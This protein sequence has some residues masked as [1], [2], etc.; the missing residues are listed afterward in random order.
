VYDYP[1]TGGRITLSQFITAAGDLSPIAV[2]EKVSLTRRIGDNLE[3][4]VTL[5]YAAI[6]QHTEP[7]IFLKPNDHISVGTS[8]GATPMAVIRNGFRTSYGFGFLL[9][10]NFGNDVFG[11]PPVTNRF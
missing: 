1:V 9:D 2:P 8:W 5:N 11:P 7:D 4:T 6:L 10:R 3:A